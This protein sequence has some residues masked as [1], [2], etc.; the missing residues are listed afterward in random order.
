MSI[1]ER[2][3]KYIKIGI[4]D[5]SSRRQQLAEYLDYLDGC[6]KVLDMG[7]G[8]GENI[9]YLKKICLEVIGI[10]L[11]EDEKKIAKEKNLRVLIRDMHDTYFGKEEFDGVLLW[12][13]LEHSP[14][15]WILMDEIYRILKP[16]GRVLVFIPDTKWIECDYH[17]SVLTQ[18]QAK[19]LFEKTG[20]EVKEMIDRG[21][22]SAVY[23]LIKK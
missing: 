19:W 18:K 2:W 5:I 6:G 7:C 21:D 11:N 4:G 8:V 20:F 23:K 1:E 13:V 17:L 14:S 12:D 15:P 10:T 16:R 9:L 22:Q 3:K